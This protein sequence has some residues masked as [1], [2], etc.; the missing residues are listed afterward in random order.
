MYTITVTRPTDD[1]S[2]AAY[3]HVKEYEIQHG[4]LTLALDD[5]HDY[6]IPLFQVTAVDIVRQD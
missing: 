6:V 1:K 5:N 4:V 3:E 2:P